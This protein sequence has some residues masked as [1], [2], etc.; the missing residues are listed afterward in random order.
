LDTHRNLPL[1]MAGLFNWVNTNCPK[2]DF[3]LKLDDD[4]YLN[5]NVL[6]NFVNT[7]RQLGKMTIFGQS[8]RTGY[9]FINNWGPQR[10]K[11]KFN[12]IFVKVSFSK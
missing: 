12:Y 1:K 3:L 8:Q 10:S 11:L 4:M 9:P 2:H 6:A 5:V 7:Y